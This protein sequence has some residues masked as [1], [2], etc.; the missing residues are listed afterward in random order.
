MI[1]NDYTDMETIIVGTFMLILYGQICMW[2]QIV[3][4]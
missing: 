3:L 1:I 2:E 4:K